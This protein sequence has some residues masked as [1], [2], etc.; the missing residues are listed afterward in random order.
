LRGGESRRIKLA[1][2]R[3]TNRRGTYG[4]PVLNTGF[5]NESHPRW[6]N[7]NEPNIAE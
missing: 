2:Q 1:T 3:C 7:I 4:V 5:E 6:A